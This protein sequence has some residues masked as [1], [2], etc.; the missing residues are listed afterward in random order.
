MNT[1]RMVI[2][3]Q[4]R[5]VLE[6]DDLSDE[7]EGW[8]E[9]VVDANVAQFTDAEYDRGVGSRR[10]SWR[11]C[12]PCT[13]PTSPSTSSA[14]RSTST[15]RDALVEEFVADALDDVRR[16]ARSRSAPS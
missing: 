7:I 11:R 12:T 9:E 3:E 2:Y 13:A 8:I 15:S 10:G 5:R 6:G 4:R 16:S 14:R 1:Q